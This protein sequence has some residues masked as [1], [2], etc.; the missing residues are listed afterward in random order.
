MTEEQF[1]TSSEK[2][3]SL[4]PCRG[5]LIKLTIPIYCTF[6]ITTNA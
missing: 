1:G 6:K 2:S 3:V 4:T 5:I